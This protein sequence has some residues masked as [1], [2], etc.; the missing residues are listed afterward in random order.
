MDYGLRY[1]YINFIFMIAEEIE[2][3]F[4]EKNNIKYSQNTIKSFEEQVELWANG[5]WNNKSQLVVF[6]HMPQLYL[7]LGLAN[8]PITIS[9]SKLDRIVN[10]FGKQRGN[11]HNLGINITKQLPQAIIK[12][13]KVLESVTVAG[14]IVIITRLL[15]SDGRTIIVSLAIDGNGHV[16]IEGVDN[17]IIKRLPAHVMT[18][19]Y[20]RNNY[21]SW[22][23]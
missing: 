10:K 16:E 21:K 23:R 19:A 1:N 3:G 15:D 18:S 12:P 5:E 14:S 20:G 11:Y 2:Y 9:A 7:K 22:I 13:L 6:K 4:E 8:K 17:T